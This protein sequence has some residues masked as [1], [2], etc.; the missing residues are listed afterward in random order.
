[1]RRIH[2]CSR[3]VEEGIVRHQPTYDTAQEIL[4]LVVKII[5]VEVT[6]DWR[7]MMSG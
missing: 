7:A 6:G 2:R 3:Q 1:M 5:D 4:L